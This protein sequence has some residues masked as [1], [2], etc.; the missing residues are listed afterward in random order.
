MSRDDTD[1]IHGHEYFDPLG[2]N[3]PPIYLNS[4]FEQRVE[5]KKSDRGVDLKY[6]R[7][8]NPTVRALERVIS[9][10]HI[11]ED[12]LCFSSGMAAISTLYMWGLKSGDEVLTTIEAYGSTIKLAEELGKL[13]IRVKKA[14]P[15]AEAISSAIGPNTRL[16]LFEAMTNPTLK[17][18]DVRAVVEA[19]RAKG[20]LVVVD[21]TFLSPVLYK[22]IK[23]GADL[24]VEST[25]KY[26]SGHNDQVGGLLAGPS[27]SILELWE[28]RRLLGNIMSPFNAYMTYRGLKTI[29]IRMKRHEENALKVA[30][31]LKERREVVEVLYPG[32]PDDEHHELASKQFSGYGGVVSFKIKGGRA[33]VEAFLKAL[34]MIMPSPSLGGTESIITYPVVSASSSI[35][36]NDRKAVGITENLLRLSVGLEDPDDIIADIER[37]FKALK[38]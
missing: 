12:S 16:I 33:E 26:I 38:S 29:G 11:S 34:K 9:K 1:A 5:A 20:A 6:S 13:G 27:R 2:A 35:N 17:V 30:K 14:Y 3:I 19:G 22:P 23:D 10:L 31:Y 18:I 4:M 24:V 21:N 15:S 28:W 7:E 36:E 37:G 8:E 32:L 25:T